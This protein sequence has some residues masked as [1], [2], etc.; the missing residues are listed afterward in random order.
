MSLDYLALLVK[1]SRENVIR[2]NVMAPLLHFLLQMGWFILTTSLDFNRTEWSFIQQKRRL[3]RF[4]A[5]NF[6]QFATST[7]QLT[8]EPRNNL[9]S[10]GLWPKDDPTRCLGGKFKESGSILLRCWLR[11]KSLRRFYLDCLSGLWHL[12]GL[13]WS[14]QILK[15]HPSKI[16][17]RLTWKLLTIKFVFT[18]DCWIGPWFQFD[19]FF[20]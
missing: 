7:I 17:L 13:V 4:V 5:R 6:F 9:L 10:H 14:Q 12:N 2:E 19:N 3:G 18:S 8:A 11:C 15:H 1:K 20:P 16:S